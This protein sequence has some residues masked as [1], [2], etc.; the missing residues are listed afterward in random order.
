MRRLKTLRLIHRMSSRRLAVKSPAEPLTD[1]ATKLSTWL[2]IPPRRLQADLAAACGVS[3]QTISDYKRRAARPDPG[4]EPAGLIE[5][6]TS[7]FVSA[8]GWLTRREA[9]DRQRNQTRAADFAR[10][11]S[12]ATEEAVPEESAGDASQAQALP[13][14]DTATQNG[15][16]SRTSRVSSAAAGAA[17]ASSR[18]GRAHARGETKGTRGRPAG[19][20]KAA[21]GRA[22]R[23]L[24]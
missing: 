22:L 9:R 11:A 17:G 14:A 10:G 8:T 15:G 6:A 12:P 21:G 1:S 16:V 24:T 3:Q 13:T 2:E 20:T 18:A 19:A 23:G 5:I 4:S 7:G